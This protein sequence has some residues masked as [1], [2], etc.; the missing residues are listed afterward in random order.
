M[1]LQ[2]LSLK[3]FRVFSN[4]DID[5]TDGINIISGL[6]GQGKTSILESIYYLS[7]TRSFKS[8]ADKNVIKYDSDYFNI[9]GKILFN[10]VKLENINLSYS[11][12]H[13]KQIY[14][15]KNKVE[16][17]SEYIG[18][19]PCVLLTLND[20]KLTLG[21]PSNRRKFIDIVLSQ[22]SKVY[23]QNLKSYK[24]IVQQKNKLLNEN[25]FNSLNNQLEVWNEQ[26]AEFGS[27][28]IQR[29]I[30]FV[31]FLNEFISEYYQ[32]FSNLKEKITV[33]NKSS[34]DLPDNLDLASQIKSILINRLNE[35]EKKERDRKTAL[36]GP[37]RDDLEFLKDGR[38][39]KE[40]GSQGENK[41]LI[42]VL[43]ILEWKYV[44]KQ[45]ENNPF[46]LLDDIF[47]ELDMSRMDGL[48]RF[49]NKTGQ[50]FIT[51]TLTNKFEVLK[52]KHM[53]YLENNKIKYARESV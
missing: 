22:V 39:F 13:K 4:I 35:L 3:N 6:N 30:E 49:L 15:K 36:I 46:M 26:L 2:N 45:N 20:L 11:E 10:D 5:F 34:F 52:S 23:L 51:T 18:K 32:K 27:F 8:S 48:L 9:K 1:F 17:F 41:T 16:K 31:K 40:Y 44:S 47:G 24:R 19:L 21:L 37:H 50:S 38:S 25:S 53:I 29:R 33:K 12:A 7:L 42:I 43:K 14:I 28:I